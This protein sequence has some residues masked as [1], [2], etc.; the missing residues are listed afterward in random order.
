MYVSLIS[1]IVSQELP[2]K[3]VLTYTWLLAVTGSPFLAALNFATSSGPTGPYVPLTSLLISKRV[4][5]S[6]V[7]KASVACLDFKSIKNSICCFV[8]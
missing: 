3:L 7:S 8:A 6:H 5:T 4:K 2:E 1:E